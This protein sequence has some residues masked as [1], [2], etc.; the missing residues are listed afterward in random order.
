MRHICWAPTEC[1]AQEEHHYTLCPR[2][3]WS[4]VR[5]VKTECIA[6]SGMK[7]AK[8]RGYGNLTRSQGLKSGFLEVVLALQA[9]G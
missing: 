7:I 2:R 1:Q 4:L 6:M 3:A 5:K 9:E 8:G